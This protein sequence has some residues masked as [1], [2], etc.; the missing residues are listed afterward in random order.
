MTFEDDVPNPEG[1][2]PVDDRVAVVGMAGRFPGANTLDQFWA[3]LRAGAE[4]IRR[5]DDDTLRAAGVDEEEIRA[6]SYVPFGAPVDAVD[7]F[8]AGFFRFTP[9]EAEGLDPQQRLFLETVYHA[10]EDAGYRPDT[11]PKQV[12]VYGGAR[13]SDYLVRHVYSNPEWLAQV[14]YFQALL[15]NDKDYLAPLTSYKLDLTGPSITVQTACSTS[16]VAVQLAMEALISHAIDMA[17]AGGVSLRFPMEAGYHH[18]PNG[19]FSSSGRVKTFDADADGTVFGNGV[20]AV[21]LKRLDEALADGDPIYGVVAAAAVNNDG[22]KKVGLTAPSAEGQSKVIADALAMAEAEPSE[23]QYVECHGTGTTLGDAIEVAALSKVFGADPDSHC[24]LGAVKTNIGHLEA[25]AGVAGL[26]KVMLML[27]HRRLVPSLH[28]GTPNPQIDFEGPGFR[29]Q[30]ADEPWPAPASGPRRAGLSSFGIGGT[31]AHLILE[32]APERGDSPRAVDDGPVLLRLSA[33]GRDAVERATETLADVLDDPGRRDGLRLVDV[34]TTLHRGRERFDERRACLARGVAE[35]GRRLRD[36]NSLIA[37]RVDATR[38]L[39]FLFPGQ[40]SQFPGMARGVYARSPIFRKTFDRGLECLG[41][42]GLDANALGEILR[43]SEDAANSSDAAERLTHTAWAQPALVLTQYALARTFQ[44]WGFEPAALMGH[45]VGQY[46]AACVAGVFSF[47]DALKLMVE[48]G[49]RIAEQ[50]PGAMVSVHLRLSELQ[51][52]WPEGLGGGLDVAA[53]NA[54]G[55]NV[56]SGPHDAVDRLVAWLEQEDIAHRRLVTS[57]AFHSS[58]VEPA[59]EPFR[60]AVAGV[61]LHAPSI[62]L[63]SNGTGQWMD[64]D[65]TRD[66]DTWVRHIRDTVHFRKGLQTLADAG[67]SLFVEMGNGRTA[68]TFARTTLPGASTVTTLP[69]PRSE[70]DPWEWVL[71]AVGRL[72]VAGFEGDEDAL[73]AGGRRISLPGYPFARERHWL[74]VGQRTPDSAASLESGASLDSGALPDLTVPVDTVT[75]DGPP[76]GTEAPGDGNR[77]EHLTVPYVA[78]DGDLEVRL[79]AIWEEQLGVSPVGREDN[80]FDLG[81]HSLLATRILARIHDELGVELELRD[82]FAPSDGGGEGRLADLARRAREAQEAQGDSGTTPRG[83]ADGFGDL[84]P[85]PEILPLTPAQER[86]WFL[87]RLN[88]S[89]PSYN[90]PGVFP[91]DGP[92]DLDVLEGALADLLERHEI[93]RS[94][95]P[96]GE[97]RPRVEILEG[98]APAVAFE[99]LA[100]LSADER[101]RRVAQHMAEDAARPFRLEEEIALRASVLRLSSDRHLFLFNLHHVITDGSSFSVLTRDLGELYRARLV[102]ESPNLPPLALQYVD[103]ALWL[104]RLLSGERQG[105]LEGFWKDYLADAPLVFDLAPD[106]ERP[107]LPDVTGGRVSIE[108]DADT[109]TGLRALARSQGATLFHVTLALFQTL[110]WNRTQ[111]PDFLV[112]THVTQRPRRELEDL[113]GLFVNQLVVRSRLTP[114]STFADLVRR[115][116]GESL[117]ALAH[118][119][120]PFERLVNLLD[121][122]REFNRNPVAQVFFAFQNHVPVDP[123]VAVLSESAATPPVSRHDMSLEMYPE[124]GLIRGALV[125]RTALFRDASVERMARDL[126]VLARAVVADAHR[127]LGDLAQGLPHL[128][129]ETLDTQR[130][131]LFEPPLAPP[132]PLPHQIWERMAREPERPAVVASEDPVPD[133][134]R[135]SYG[136]LDHRS[137]RVAAALRGLGVG[138]ETP[139]ALVTERSAAF[140]VGWLGIWRAGGAVVPLELDAP[141]KRLE[142]QL[143]KSGARL[144]LTVE[145]WLERLPTDGGLRTVAMDRLDVDR[146]DRDDASPA[147]FED[148]EI[149]PQQLSHIIFTSG[150]TGEP[151]GVALEHRHIATYIQGV[152]QRLGIDDSPYA[153]V[154]AV[155]ADAGHTV[156]FAP[157]CEGGCLH[158]IGPD[159]LGRPAA[160]EAYMA[161]HRIHSLK[162]MPS[163]LQ[164]LHVG[165]STP[166]MP[167][168]HLLLGGESSA[169]AWIEG[170]RE[171]HPRVELVNHYG[172]TETSVGACVQHFERMGSELDTRTIGRPLPGLRVYVVDALDRPLPDG[173]VGELYLAGPQVSRGYVGQPALT[174][175]RFLPDPWSPEPGG[176]RYRTG[177]QARVDGRSRVVF[178]GRGDFQI[179]LRGFRIEPGEV[180]AVLSKHP[181]VAQAVVRLA[182]EP[183]RL[184]AYVVPE[185]PEF[186]REMAWEDDLRGWAAERLPSAMVPS[187]VVP[188]DA[189]PLTV[190]G[191]LDTRALPQDLDLDAREIRPPSTALERQLAV[192]WAQILGLEQPSLDDNFFEVG[193]DSLLSIRLMALAHR[194]RLPLTPQMLFQN[195]TL[196][197]LASAL[198]TV[199]E[200]TGGDGADS[201]ALVLLQPAGTGPPVLCVHPAGGMVFG[202]LDLAQALGDTQPFYGVQDVTFQRETLGSYAVTVES[203]A[204]RYLPEILDTLPSGPVR[205]MGHSFGG[206]VAFELAQRLRAMGRDVVELMLLDTHPPRADDPGTDGGSG[207]DDD[208]AAGV[209]PRLETLVHIGE[210]LHRLRGAEVPWSFE[211]LA[212]VEEPERL[213][214]VSESLTRLDGYGDFTPQRLGITLTLYT[215][216]HLAAQAYR[217]KPWGGDLIH[218]RPAADGPCGWEPW[219]EGTLEIRNVG[220]DHNTMLMRGFVEEIVVSVNPKG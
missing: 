42:L 96:Y 21:V 146:L 1:E 129:A 92:F 163:L 188:I 103:Y 144:V 153:L 104:D 94:R 4:S 95:F 156:L 110:L 105:E 114:A 52:R 179:K 126:E 204:D 198:H 152:I 57:H 209:D 189:V 28:F 44:A 206:L 26:I 15:G 162:T 196:G 125:F 183:P 154:S 130:Q 22:G 120:Y 138:A 60:R 213:E 55:L 111:N 35:A 45:S 56:L 58:T 109:T 32:E 180:E 70:G 33:R 123:E 90:L 99:D 82:F 205:L 79:A 83:S 80:F 131:A 14:G 181:A 159:T 185:S 67:P 47:E 157:L 160:F 11:L 48:R 194:A 98:V 175:E 168:K 31:N 132:P 177:D 6:P 122:R 215:A 65:A 66:P 93:L 148:V 18:H 54:P 150:S 187:R 86:L 12:G 72:W 107:E 8:D 7:R 164:A 141:S 192:L 108:L 23:V 39:V 212:Q 50:P 118:A 199:L 218:V 165:S 64:D 151:K 85:R 136:E 16:L 155:S 19:I 145:A 24:A 200:R 208:G 193:G 73:D 128:D 124:E 43:L 2:E 197:A 182:G 68:S 115:V 207:T 169:Q 3:N 149:E 178:L 49:R 116:R 63:I 10:L 139:V 173:R 25:A 102:G 174:A 77:P 84:G 186:S 71:G 74:D 91:I 100:G 13:F 51:D 219:V 53:R 211:T 166:A 220:G 113:V 135:L 201:R 81:G 140:V 161:E 75:V 34:A 37:G 112:G 117:Q 127:T 203:L 147:S 88:P 89:D 176:H 76:P 17:V 133:F 170:L 202:Y 217:P 46:T 137:R 167:E 210:A 195:Q 9:R 78:P 5:F 119:D 29:V 106:F 97:T 87:Q 62:P 27:K 172:P 158:V 190:S 142:L 121:S 171:S 59:L 143:R 36:G 191:K 20:G 41:R 134:R 30:T 69:G 38:R 184:V 101:A 216:H 40:G 61:D 214:V